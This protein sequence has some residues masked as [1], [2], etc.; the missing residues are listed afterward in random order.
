MKQMAPTG[1]PLRERA[2]LL[3]GID[4]RSLALLRIV[5]G[6]LLLYDLADRARLLTAN[7]ADAGAHPRAVVLDYYE[8]W[9]LPSLHLMAGSARVQLVLFVLAGIAAALLAAGWRTRLVTFVSW[10]LLGSLH[11]RNELVLDGGDHL[12][13]H[14]LFWSLF[15]PLGARWSLDARRRGAPP[16]SSVVCSPASAALLLQVAAVFFVTGLAKTGPEW[17]AD[18]TAIRYALDRKWWIQPF[19]EW[20]LT[21]PFLPELLTPAVRWWEIAGPLLLFVPVATVPLRLLGIAGFL[22]LLAGLG[23]G[24][25]L[26]LFPFITGSG[27]LAFLPGA[28]WDW[29]GRRFALFRADAA[30]TPEPSTGWRRWAANLGHALVLALLLLLIGWGNASTLNPSLSPPPPLA[31][32][33]SLLHIEQGWMMYAPSPRHIDVWFEH[34]GRLAN[35]SPVDLDHA[36]AGGAGWAQ[37]EQAWQDYRFRYYLQKLAIPRWQGALRAYAEWLCRQW[38]QDRE[39]GARLDHVSVTP[40]IE[41]IAIRDE[42]QQPA[43]AQPATTLLCPR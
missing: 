2:R 8:P 6:T 13:R 38:N 9:L 12:L 41:P 35:G 29:L 32:I 4:I 18:D 24:L 27:L 22:G 26:N 37:V 11:A 34:R 36:A 25:E 16:A 3:F 21:Q 30:A 10:F 17:T 23:L 28:A 5:A 39:G 15:L 20:L 42:P 14:L 19:G 40:I 7:Y 31:S 1:P 33:P 43:T